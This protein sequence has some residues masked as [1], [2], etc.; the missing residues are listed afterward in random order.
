MIELAPEAKPMLAPAISDT[1]LELPFKLKFVTATPDGPIMVMAFPAWLKVIL[2]PPAKVNVPE[3]IN[4]V[5]PAVFPVMETSLWTIELFVAEIV[6]VLAEE[7]NATPAPAT[8]ESAPDDPLR[9]A[10]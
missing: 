10:T 8:S 9:L 2:F 3:E 6:M 5:A 7:L 1:L 4:E